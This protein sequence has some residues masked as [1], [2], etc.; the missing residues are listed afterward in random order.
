MSPRIFFLTFRPKSHSP[1]RGSARYMLLLR[2]P[3]HG[4]R[5]RTKPVMVHLNQVIQQPAGA[6]SNDVAMKTSLLRS[7]HVWRDMRQAQASSGR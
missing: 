3:V 7:A 6:S 2:N 4:E 5:E 1:T